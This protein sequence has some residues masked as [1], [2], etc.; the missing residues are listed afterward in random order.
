MAVVVVVVVVV[1]V[2]SR[3]FASPHP[4]KS[5]EFRERPEAARKADVALVDRGKQ[6]AKTQM[7]HGPTHYWQTAAIRAL[8]LSVNRAG[9]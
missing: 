3:G 2:I 9:G 1:V 6:Q 8:L 7:N 5:F 4:P